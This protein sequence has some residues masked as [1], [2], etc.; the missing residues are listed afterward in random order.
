MQS[1]DNGTM[2]NT[3]NIAPHSTTKF[4]VT[5]TTKELLLIDTARLDNS[6]ELEP[7]EHPAP[8]K[9]IVKQIL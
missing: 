2:K 4:Q 8:I 6:K 9:N 1:I 3:F 7:S 5:S